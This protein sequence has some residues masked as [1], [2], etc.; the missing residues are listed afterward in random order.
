MLDSKDYE[1]IDA[2]R[3]ADDREVDVRADDD[4]NECMKD[5]CQDPKL[6]YFLEPLPISM[7][8]ILKFDF[9]KF[10]LASNQLLNSFTSL[11]SANA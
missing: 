1:Y 7:N 2:A 10:H 4:A 6:E 9:E 5:K 11:I 8:P 3:I